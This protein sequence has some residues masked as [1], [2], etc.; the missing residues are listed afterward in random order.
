MQFYSL[1]WDPAIEPTTSPSQEN[2]VTLVHWPDKII[3]GTE[4]HCAVINNHKFFSVLNCEL[5]WSPSD[6]GNR[7]PIRVFC[8]SRSS[9]PPRTNP[10]LRLWPLVGYI[11]LG[12]APTLLERLL[13]PRWNMHETQS[14][15]MPAEST[16]KA[17]HCFLLASIP[18]A[19]QMYR[20]VSAPFSPIERDTC[21]D[22]LG[23]VLE[24]SSQFVCPDTP[25]S[26]SS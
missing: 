24:N 14:S 6:F 26:F 15:R 13:S 17:S 4:K 2:T 16:P 8:A 3:S 21:L 18:L 10:F 25:S 9:L 1:W 5:V 19:Y 11:Y 22:L 7:C 12:S 23:T 20:F